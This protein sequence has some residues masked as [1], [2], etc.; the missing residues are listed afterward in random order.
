[1]KTIFLACITLLLYTQI[2]RAN[3]SDPVSKY[4]MTVSLESRIENDAVSLILHDDQIGVYHHFILEKSL[5]GKAFFEVTRADEV[6]D[7]DGS[8]TITFKDYP[9]EKSSM[10]CVFYRIRAVDELGWFDFTNTVTVMK[11]L[12]LAVKSKPGTDPEFEK[13]Q[14]QF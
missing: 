12:D 4:R 14:N 13:R 3:I 1:M 6:K 5:D 10:T 11:K 8:R 9:F 7:N 2:S